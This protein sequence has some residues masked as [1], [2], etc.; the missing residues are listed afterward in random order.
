M[1]DITKAM[2]AYKG[3]MEKAMA[4]I[5]DTLGNSH[6]TQGGS[7]NIKA[8]SST[9]VKGDTA[10]ELEKLNPLGEL[11]K[12]EFSKVSDE[13]GALSTITKAMTENFT[14]LDS[15]LSTIEGTSRGR[16][17]VS[18]AHYIEKGFEGNNTDGS[19]TLSMSSNKGEILAVLESRADFDINKGYGNMAFAEAMAKYESTNTID[20]AIVNRLRVDNKINVI[21]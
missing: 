14:S 1:A 16:K 8:N 4:T 13:I 6:E 11:V 15:R 17:S 5:G 19:Q 9:V 20:T 10:T 21:A 7:E 18:N 2:E 12:A 3:E